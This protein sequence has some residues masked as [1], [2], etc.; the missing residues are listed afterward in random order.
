MVEIADIRDRESVRVWLKGRSRE[1][2]VAIAHRAAMRVL[3]V[4]L[5][6]VLSEKEA[7]AG[8]LT[9]IPV[10]WSSLISGVVGNCPTQEISRIATSA[11]ANAANAAISSATIANAAVTAANAASTIANAAN[12]ATTTIAT[13]SA[14]IA[15][16]ANAANAATA[17][18]TIVNAAAAAIADG[19]LLLRGDFAAILTGEALKNT[20]L[21]GGE[22]S[23]MAAQWTETKE[24]MAQDA[25]D[26]S[27]WIKWYEAALSGIPAPCAL[28]VEIAKID[29]TDWEQ[30][31]AHVN[32]LIAGIEEDFLLTST[33]VAEKIELSSETERLRITPERMSQKVLYSNLLEVIQDGMADL[34]DNPQFD[35]ALSALGPV[36]ETILDRTFGKYLSSPQRVHDDFVKAKRRI[37]KLLDV[38]ELAPNDEVLEFVD[39]LDAGAAHIRANMPQV[40]DSMAALAA[41]RIAEASD[42]DI[43]G[44]RAGAEAIA[45]QSEPEM[46]EE[47][48]EDAAELLAS[49]DV[50]LGAPKLLAP[51]VAYRLAHRVVESKRILTAANVIKVVKGVRAG[52]GD[53]QIV[54]AIP[55][56]VE[57]LIR[58]L[59]F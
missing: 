32:G 42:A 11:A 40:R 35:N 31:P 14:S 17:N 9:A 41:L 45:A 19:W 59:R 54:M 26:W 38:G 39:D 5:K 51:D 50:S 15:N 1:E 29:P 52:F 49:R 48:R 10:L 25:E 22:G 28:L 18:A 24:L 30:G 46:A 3:P 13:S 34:R 58:L 6:W 47:M 7:R 33:P 23:P 37:R 20:A 4:Y 36:F 12:A 27:F 55:F 8:D 21:W 56:A 2:A 57:I 44:I 53:T 43:A 16:A